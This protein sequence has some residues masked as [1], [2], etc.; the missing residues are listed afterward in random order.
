MSVQR[1]TVGVLVADDGP[2]HR[3]RMAAAVSEWP[4]LELLAE[5]STA[6]DIRAAV[7]ELEPD[8]TLVDITMPGLDLL[9]ALARGELPTRVVVISAH[10]E[11]GR[12][13]AAIAAGVEAYV[14]KAATPAQVCGLIAALARGDD[15]LPAELQLG[16]G[17]EIH[18][19]EV[20]EAPLLSTREY[21]VLMLIGG[22][23]S[24]DEV[25][26]RLYLSPETLGAYV[27]GFCEKLEVAEVPEAVIEGRRRGL[28]T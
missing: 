28:I 19:R 23:M 25:C 1:S 6:R 2:K 26:R 24:P 10:L 9:G 22:G 3:E 21:Q 12:V 11:G 17:G 15:G 14:S 5:V 13:R 18:P 8:V 16:P 7:R 27:A 20:G 4:E